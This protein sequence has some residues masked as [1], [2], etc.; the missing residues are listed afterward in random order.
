MPRRPEI[1]HGLG[2]LLQNAIEFAK[3]EVQVAIQWTK[4]ELRVTITDDGIGFPPDL[5]DRLGDPYISAALGRYGGKLVGRGGGSSQQRQNSRRAT[6]RREGD[7]MG[8]GIFIAQNLLERSGGNVQFSNNDFGGAEV[9]VVWPRSA[10]SSD[11][12]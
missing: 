9:K 4:Q 7:H 1:M 5:L 10:W 6:N 8:L 3:E 2:N 12:A 11:A